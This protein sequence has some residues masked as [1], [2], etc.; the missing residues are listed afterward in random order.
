MTDSFLQETEHLYAYFKF[1]SQLVNDDKGPILFRGQKCCRWQ[2]AASAERRIQ[3]DFGYEIGEIPGDLYYW[4]HKNL[5]DQ[6]KLKGLH[7]R[8]TRELFDLEIL[9]ELQHYGA[10]TGLLDFSRNS[11]IALWFACEPCDCKSCYYKEN[12]KCDAQEVPHGA[13][14]ILSNL[15]K[16]LIHNVSYDTLSS[17]P[18]YS[19]LLNVSE[20]PPH[21]CSTDEIEDIEEEKRWENE[22]KNHEDNIK[23]ENDN[24]NCFSGNP[25]IW[26]WESAFINDHIPIQQS[27]FIF[28]FN[29]IPKKSI[30]KLEI[31]HEHK[32]TIRNLL[33]LFFNINES[34]LFPDI[35]GY[36][37]INRSHVTYHHWSSYDTFLAGVSL[38]KKVEKMNPKSLK[39]QEMYALSQKLVSDNPSNIKSWRSRDYYMQK[40]LE[41]NSEIR[42]NSCNNS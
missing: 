4:Y 8:E 40:I 41:K 13:V 30:T 9:A 5:I 39:V 32:D 27:A 20:E 14:I 7:R 11:L 19:F 38:F 36:S 42:E 28:G 18:L 23:Q 24:F 22:R 25:L 17:Y 2:L 15:N 12:R 1:I 37:Q 29:S 6:I 3:A 34:T 31:P 16:N 21:Y 33:N 10:A 26:F 35:L